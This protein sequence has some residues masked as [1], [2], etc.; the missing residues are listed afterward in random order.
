MTRAR[1]KLKM[2]KS[3]RSTN[4]SLNSSKV[5]IGSPRNR[6][7]NRNVLGCLLT[8]SLF[9]FL[10]K[11]GFWQLERGNEKQTMEQQL[12]LR[13]QQA[14]LSYNEILINSTQQSLTGFNL[15]V[16][17]SPTDTP[18]IFLDNQTFKN[19]VGYLAYQ[20][21]QISVDQPWL[22]VELGF[23][24]VTAQRSTLPSLQP[25]THTESL[26]GRVYQRQINPLSHDLFAESGNP[27]RIQNL[28]IQQLSHYI[29]H[30]LAPLVLQPE[31]VVYDQNHQPLGKPWQP[32]P[33]SSD[34]HF[35]YAVQW[36]SMASALLFIGLFVFYTHRKKITIKEHG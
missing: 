31:T 30:P 29:N 12:Q 32:L 19:R 33:L 15:S 20:V 4:T 36:F 26:S 18:I 13:Q 21:M 28:N 34:K 24:P 6:L 5:S 7:F 22:L 27:T 3:S 8:L 17:V 23:I 14:P 1:P 2:M 25:F 16:Q 10:I 11:L 35:G 9:C